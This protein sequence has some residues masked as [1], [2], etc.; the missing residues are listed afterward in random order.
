[1]KAAFTV[2]LSLS[3]YN[4][5]TPHELNLFIKGYNDRLIRDNKE[6]LTLA[7]LTAAW[8]RTKKLPD[9]KKILKED[10]SNKQQTA[11]EML[12]IVKQLNAVFGGKEVKQEVG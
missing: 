10:T 1:M 2:G 11:E 4:G 9:L 8:G 3:E 7:Y 5:M 6:G 12:N